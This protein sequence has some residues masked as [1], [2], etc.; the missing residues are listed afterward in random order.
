MI[1][2]VADDVT[3]SNDIGLMFAKHNYR[4][5]IYSEYQ[6]LDLTMLKTD[7]LIL[8]TNSRCDE[9]Q[10]AYQKVFD[11]TKRLL[12]LK[13][14]LLHKKACSVLRGNVGTEFD[15]ML[16]AAGKDFAV[17]VAAFPKNGRTTKNGIHYVHGKLLE[18]SEFAH[19]P[20]HPMIVSDLRTIVG[21][22]ARRPLHLLDYGIVGQGVD[23]IRAKIEDYR[24]QSGYVI[25]DVLGQDELHVLAE[26][27]AAEPFIMGSSAIGEEL[28][29]FWPPPGV[30]LSLDELPRNETG[31][32][33]ISGS[34]TPQT[35]NQVAY[36][37][38]HGIAARELD[39]TTL[40]EAQSRQQE[41]ERLTAWAVSLLKAGKPALLYGAHHPGA[42]AATYEAASQAGFDKT[43]ANH[44]VS[45]ILGEL[46][47]RIVESADVRHLIVL[48]GETSNDVCRSL[49]IV[50]N[51]V[52]KEIQPGLPSGL[53]FGKH[54]L[55][56]VFK[57]GS[58]GTADFLI[59]TIEHLENL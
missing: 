56:V 33:M 35:R 28:P 7:V 53:S 14:R 32:F 39:P 11:A 40:F 50:G 29:H 38:K 48:G 37:Q 8:D 20:V 3:G 58:F 2:I 52:L 24:Q 15:A 34:V 47:L 31:T 9:P 41:L 55:V 36:A 23:A 45:E 17:L 30:G 13:C 42:I 27:I 19:D 49:G 59:Q 25:C 43:Q 18:K 6:D 10:S 51:L 4:V 54:Q 5:E 21:Q 46:S 22:Q 1:G 26:A 44:R 12:P 16:D 57:S